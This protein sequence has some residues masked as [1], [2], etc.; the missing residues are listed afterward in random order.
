LKIEY[1]ARLARIA[2]AAHAKDSIDWAAVDALGIRRLTTDSR[3]VRAGDTF[4]AYP[5]ETRDGREFITQALANGAASI[6]TEAIDFKGKFSSRIPRLAIPNLRQCI[7]VIASHI[8]GRPSS[9]LWI[10]GVTGTN[11]KTSCSLWIAHALSAAGRKCA[12]VGTLG[13]GFP[14]ALVAGV[15]TTP[16]AAWLHGQL[17]DWEREGAHAVSMEVSS[18][19]LTQG[20]VAGVDFDVA[21]F[22]NLT[23]DHLDYHGDMRGYRSAKAK[24]FRLDSLKHAVLNLDDAF[25]AELA[26][27]AYPARVQVLGY[28]F[29]A[30]RSAHRR[31]ERVQ[32][33]KL[34]VGADGVSFD[35]ITPWGRA[36]VK[37]GLLGRFN[38]SNLLAALSA[39][40]VS[41]VDFCDA[42]H[43]L[44]NVQPAPGRAERYGGGIHPVVVVD[45]AHT[46]DALEKILLA[47][48][49]IMQ[50][51]MRPDT[52]PRATRARRLYC[53]FGCGG[54]RDRG[55]RAQMGRIATRCAD[56][57]VVTS[58][59][60]RTEDPMAIIADILEGASGDCMVIA[61]RARAVRETIAM[62]RRGDVVVV[63]GKGHEPYQEIRG[64][65]RRYSDAGTV[66]A[67]LATRGERA[68]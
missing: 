43:A 55:K 48:R 49:E 50:P 3:T 18:H 60:P 40:L 12:V 24:L 47:M 10:A 59:N 14:D 57:V 4:V 54:D 34:K 2:R 38:A 56:R 25:G 44:Q 31:I 15:N 32:G 1:Q 61:D 23:R 21:V 64:V 35:V 37:S 62:A 52:Q 63:A 41:N 29:G 28:G 30:A 26:V 5:G 67:A 36:H 66:Q 19:G 13:N 7:G 65:R 51:A 33:R 6:L 42:V 45:Y 27:R 20:R 68:A 8:Y 53:V 17:R 46:P 39:L 16:D 58:D 9:R 22:T 11:G